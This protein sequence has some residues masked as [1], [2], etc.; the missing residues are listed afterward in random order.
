MVCAAK[1]KMVCCDAGTDVVKWGSSFW[2]Q[3]VVG[4]KPG[5]GSD[6]L[7]FLSS[8]RVA[9]WVSG[10]S[11]VKS[12]I[13]PVIGLHILKSPQHRRKCPGK[14]CGNSIIVGRRY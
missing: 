10:L 1:K 14:S 11:D 2:D 12:E 3:E 13:L 4:S 8:P 7:H 9:N 6:S 5:S